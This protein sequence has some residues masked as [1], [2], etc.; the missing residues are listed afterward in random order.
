MSEPSNAVPPRLSRL[1][2]AA[3]VLHLLFF[4][5]IVAVG[6]SSVW[7]KRAERA[8][9]PDE[10]LWAV[11]GLL[12]FF[13]LL[14]AGFHWFV[15]PAYYA[16][17]AAKV[18]DGQNPLRFLEYS[19]SASA[20]LVAVAI[21][22]GVES[23]LWLAA[24]A[25][26]SAAVMALGYV[27]EKYKAGEYAWSAAAWVLLLGAYASIFYQF[28]EAAQHAAPPDFVYALVVLMFLLFCSFGAVQAVWLARNRER[29]VNYEYAYLW[30]SVVAKSLLVLLTASGVPPLLS[31]QNSAG[32]ELKT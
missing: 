4:I 29:S 12:A 31:A 25:A 23:P 9:M 19:L 26:A 11:F 13:T 24:L 30:L 18:R 17:N 6:A 15:Y 2:R 10:H 14:T 8:I 16:R 5:A 27:V 7:G 22:S 20:M 3:G 32:G 21:L 28:H 1:S